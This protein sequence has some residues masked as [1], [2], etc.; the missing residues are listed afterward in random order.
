MG[1]TTQPTTR[2]E[3]GVRRTWPDRHSE[4][5]P[6]HDRH[7]AELSALRAPGDTFTAEVVS[8]VVTVSG[9]EPVGGAT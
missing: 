4:V 6:Y 5:K 8:R 1:T 7:A 3:F 9:W 2:T